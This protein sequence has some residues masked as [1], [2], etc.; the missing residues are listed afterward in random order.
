MSIQ[1]TIQARADALPPSSRRVADAIVADPQL[2]MEKTIS[3]LARLCQTSET[4]VVRFCRSMGMAGYA[5]LRIALAAEL[6]RERAQRAASGSVAGDERYGS[7]ISHNDD[8]ADAIAKVAFSQ[9]L[10]IEETVGGLDVGALALAVD[11]LDRARRVIVFGIGASALPAQDLQAKLLRIGRTVF[12][13]AGAHDAM[14][15]A[16]LATPEDVVVAFSHSGTTLEPVELVRLARSTGA[17]TLAVTNGRGSPLAS[18]VD[19]ALFT[20]ARETRFRAAAMA[21][22][23]AQFTLVD[24]LFVGVAQRRHDETTLALKATHEATEPLR[25]GGTTTEPA[26]RGTA[27]TEPARRG[28][29]TTEPARRGTTAP[30]EERHG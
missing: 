2:V 17:T 18:A 24:C 4:S 30:E 9:R 25:R 20:A 1:S 12:T 27:T 15:V 7:D 8:L 29:T 21:S 11:A 5:H 10:S 22:R 23:T 16:S 3:E 28:T 13:F 6:G 19:I 26:R 14:A